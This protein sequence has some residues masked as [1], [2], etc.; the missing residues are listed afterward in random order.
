MNSTY[1]LFFFKVLRVCDPDS[2]IIKQIRLGSTKASYVVSHGLG[3]HFHDEIIKDIIASL[4][5]V[6]GIDAS[7]FKMG[8]LS[9]HVDLV[10][11]FWSE[12]YGQVV[13]AYIDTHLFGHEP[14]DSQVR[15]CYQKQLTTRRLSL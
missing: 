7:T 10:I 3:P 13:D 1:F 15:N 2:D 9:K 12:K 11:R 4:G 14:A 6:L 5:Y 8:G